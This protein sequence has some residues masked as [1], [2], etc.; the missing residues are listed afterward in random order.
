MLGG[1]TPQEAVDRGLL[2]PSRCDFTVVIMWGRM[3]TPLSEP[4]KP[5]GSEYSSGTEYEFEEARASGR[6][7]LVY[8]RTGSIPVMLEDPELDAKRA[9][10]AL[11]DDFFTRF[12]NGDGSF[13]AGYNTYEDLDAFRPKFEAHV[14]AVVREMLDASGVEHARS[15]AP[16]PRHETK[17]SV[18]VDYRQWLQ[19]RCAGVELLGLGDADG[20]APSAR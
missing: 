3:G 8:R 13:A 20:S 17:P 6:P 15:K 7:L 2:P 16:L 5:D 14:K 10:K 9:Q 1:L 19:R 11:V 18:P 12:K 4:R